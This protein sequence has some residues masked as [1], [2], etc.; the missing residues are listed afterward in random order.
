MRIYFAEKFR[1]LWDTRYITYTDKYRYPDWY[2][3]Y[4]LLLFYPFHKEL[5]L[6]SRDSSTESKTLFED[7]YLDVANYRKASIIPNEVLMDTEFSQFRNDECHNMDSYGQQE[8][9]EMLEEEYFFQEPEKKS[10][11]DF[12]KIKHIQRPIF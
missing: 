2:A 10:A 8:K 1:L 9:E 5:Q 11:V 6:N 12:I 7:G 4:L 3:N